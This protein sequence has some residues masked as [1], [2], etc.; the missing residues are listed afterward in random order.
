VEE[1]QENQNMDEGFESDDEDYSYDEDEG[2]HIVRRKSK[3][4]R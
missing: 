3:F 2:G 4:T 1:V